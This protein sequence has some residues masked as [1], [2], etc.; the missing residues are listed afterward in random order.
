MRKK[1]V[2]YAFLAIAALLLTALP[3]IS[4]NAQAKSRPQT[5]IADI[6][7]LHVQGNQLVNW[8]G[9]SI[10]LLGV[11]RSGTEYKCVNN[12]GIFD[13]PSDAA[14]VDAI[15]SWHVNAVRVPLNED[16]WLG[17]NGVT[18]ADAGINYRAA[19]IKYALLLNSRGIVPILDLHWTAPG[20]TLAIGQQPMPD[21]DHSIAFW[22]SVASTFKYD[23]SVVFNLFNEPHANNDDNG[24][25]WLNG[26]TAPDTAPCGSVDFAAAGMQTLV[27]QVRQ[28]GAKNVIMLD[29]WGYANYIGGVLAV[30]PNDPLHNLMISAHV[31]NFSGCTTTDCFNQQYLPVAQQLP[32]V[33]GEIGENDCQHSFIDGVMDWAD[34]NN[35]GYLGWAWDTYDCSSFPSLISNY[36]GTPTPFGIGLKDRL[37]ALAQK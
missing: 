13:G 24:L 18:A 33:L 30:L 37:S 31:Y 10:R 2:R 12:A 8:Q 4:V 19:I 17:I 9:Q 7:G 27:N 11:N 16:C 26:S 23:S 29:G 3:A 32:L 36:D 28:V 14:S 5:Q 20:S 21:T 34:Q 6:F 1:F 35:V 25:C 22:K 15:A